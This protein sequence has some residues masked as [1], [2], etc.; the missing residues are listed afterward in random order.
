[1]NIL[2]TRFAWINNLICKLVGCALGMVSALAF[3]EGSMHPQE[4]LIVCPRCGKPHMHDWGV[5]GPMIEVDTETGEMGYIDEDDDI[6][7]KTLN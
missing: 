4:V 1:M 7:P 6:D 3:K 5:Q 2:K